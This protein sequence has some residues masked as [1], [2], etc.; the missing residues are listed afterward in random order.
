M[1]VDLVFQTFTSRQTIAGGAGGGGL[2]LMV[3]AVTVFCVLFLR[4]VHRV[5]YIANVYV[6]SVVK[7]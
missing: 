6:K 1:L 7:I 3:T 4:K 5:S 2:L